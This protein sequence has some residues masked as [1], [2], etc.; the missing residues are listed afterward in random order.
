M[1]LVEFYALYPSI[2]PGWKERL[3]PI[4]QYLTQLQTDHIGNLEVDHMQARFVELLD[5]F[6]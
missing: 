2:C 3:D 6:C 1:G 4:P 5:L